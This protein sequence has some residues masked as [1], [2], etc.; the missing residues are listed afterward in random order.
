MGRGPQ[1]VKTLKKRTL[2]LKEKT[3]GV[4]ARFQPR[5]ESFFL[6]FWALGWAWA[7]PRLIYTNGAPPDHQNT[8]RFID[9]THMA[10]RRVANPYKTCRLLRLLGPFWQNG[11]KKYQK[12]I[13]FISESWLRFTILQIIKKAL[14]LEHFG[15]SK[16]GWSKYLMKPVEFWSFWCPKR[17]MASKLIKRH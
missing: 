4:W 6:G 2:P 12:S 1:M 13:R 17:K 14:V 16:K 3:S 9:K 11:S 8:I 7:W 10:F 5:R 15:A